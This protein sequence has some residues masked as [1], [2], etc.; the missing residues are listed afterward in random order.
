MKNSTN[1]IEATRY[2]PRVAASEITIFLKIWLVKRELALSD[3][4]STRL[5]MPLTASK[6]ADAY[7]K[8]IRGVS[9]QLKSKAKQNKDKDKDRT[10]RHINSNQSK[11]NHSKRIPPFTPLRTIPKRK[12]ETHQQQTD[13]KVVQNCVEDVD[14]R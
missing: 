9:A 8:I 13:I 4:A 1:M 6:S 11:S 2:N 5:W 10:Y 12:N 14:P 3:P 7:H